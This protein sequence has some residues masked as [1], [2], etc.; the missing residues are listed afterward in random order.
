MRRLLFAVMLILVL[1]M[2]ANAQT[3][4]GAINGR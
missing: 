1:A 4:R 2:G 3:F